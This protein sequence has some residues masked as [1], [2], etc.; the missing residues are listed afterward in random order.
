MRR[1][2]ALNMARLGFNVKELM[3]G[4]DWW[5]RDGYETEGLQTTEGRAL[6]CGCG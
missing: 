6:V 4:Q 3:D 2:S 5:I 1:P